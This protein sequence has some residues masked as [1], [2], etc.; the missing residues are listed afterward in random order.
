M[1]SLALHVVS[2]FITIWIIFLYGPFWQADVSPAESNLAFDASLRQRNPLWG[3]RHLDEVTHLAKEQGLIRQ[4]VVPM[5]A[6]N[7]SVVFRKE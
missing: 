6:N 2:S 7:L 5:P 1:A 3:I 4:A